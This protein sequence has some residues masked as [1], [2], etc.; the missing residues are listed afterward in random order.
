[1]NRETLK[2]LLGAVAFA[3]LG[4][5]TII[6]DTRSIV[7]IA[8]G[9]LTLAFGLFGVVV[10][11]IG[12]VRGSTQQPRFRFHTR[13]PPDI[14]VRCIPPADEEI[15]EQWEHYSPTQPLLS[16][17][18]TKSKEASEYRW[19]VGVYLA[20]FAR[21]LESEPIL[22]PAIYEALKNTAKVVDVRRE[23]TEVWVVSGEPS[24]RELVV[25]AGAAVAKC[26]PLIVPLIVNEQ[27]GALQSNAAGSR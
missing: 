5:F 4:I 25:N 1:M 24:G 10:I 2:G 17:D 9:A 13:I 23:D 21:D 14:Q 18:A 12:M 6:I 27:A 3:A 19:Q 26:I 11:A 22:V 7:G 8:V 20:E 15:E 16:I